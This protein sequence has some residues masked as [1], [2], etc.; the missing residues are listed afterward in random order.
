MDYEIEIQETIISNGEYLFVFHSILNYHFHFWA[1][2]MIFLFSFIT[3][4]SI[5]FL[6]GLIHRDV[7]I[8]FW[9]IELESFIISEYFRFFFWRIFSKLFRKFYF[10]FDVDLPFLRFFFSSAFLRDF[11]D[12]FQNHFRIKDFV[13]LKKTCSYLLCLS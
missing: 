2:T 10:R 7:C 3:Y 5:G 13:A 6:C 8:E 4:F 12:A 11:K 1:D 9:F